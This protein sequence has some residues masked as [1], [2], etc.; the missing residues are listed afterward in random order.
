V[1]LLIKAFDHSIDRVLI[2]L[3]KPACWLRVRRARKRCYPKTHGDT[4]AGVGPPNRML[5]CPVKRDEYSMIVNAW[6][7]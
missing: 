3:R 1:G 2:L 6:K 5:F 4:P 7:R